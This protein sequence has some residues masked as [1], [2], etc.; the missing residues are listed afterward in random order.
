MKPSRTTL[1]AILQQSE[2]DFAYFDRWYAA[3]PQVEAQIEPKTWTPKLK[4]I[5]FFSQVWGFL[6]ARTGLKLATSMTMPGEWLIRQHTYARARTK[7]QAAK[8]RGLK[9]IAF[10]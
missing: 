7:L 5:K 8:S 10:S 9:I 3:H 2:Y 1:L 4:F 6:P